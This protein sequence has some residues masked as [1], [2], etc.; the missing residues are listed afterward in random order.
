MAELVAIVYPD[1]G[2]AVGAQIEAARL[3]HDLNLC[4]DATAAIVRG[5]DGRFKVHTTA[6]GTMWG[7]FWELLFGLLLFVPIFGVAVGERVGALM[8]GIQKA[9]VD[10]VFQRDVQ[11]LLQP[12][13]SAL[14][15]SLDGANPDRVVS[16]L[17]RYGGTVLRAPLAAEA[18]LLGAPAGDLVASTA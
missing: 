8:E 7:M 17:S 6:N 10:K 18:S 13:T 1:E 3:A 2:T 15:L 12:G 9:G 11:D 14:F 5:R 16:A 4:P